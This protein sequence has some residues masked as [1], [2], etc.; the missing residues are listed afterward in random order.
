[1]SR[2]RNRSM[3]GVQHVSNLP[4]NQNLPPGPDV[5]FGAQVQPNESTEIDIGEGQPQGETYPAVEGQ[6]TAEEHK[7]KE[8]A[9]AED[10]VARAKR[11]S[12]PR[13]M[14]PDERK[15]VGFFL[16]EYIA[17]KDPVTKVVNMDQLHPDIKPWFYPSMAKNL[18]NR[19]VFNAVVD[20]ET[21][22][23]TG[24]Y[25]TE[26]GADLYF[27]MNRKPDTVAKTPGRKGRPAANSPNAAPGEVKYPD[28]LR[29]RKLVEGNPRQI[30]SHGYHAFNLYEDGMTYREYLRKAYDKT[31]RSEGTGAEFSGP[32]LHHWDWDL[33]HGFIGI[34]HE[35]QPEMLDDGSPNPNFWF[36]NLASTRKMRK[37]NKVE[38]PPV[39][40]EAEAETITE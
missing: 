18:I 22:S 17:E 28:N 32:K 35:D 10:R 23:L 40:A 39:E 12:G 33:L 15:V 38:Q 16:T 30:G 6:M 37:S 3:S 27:R 14:S 11:A 24:V 21:K 31:L 7:A 1:M 20:E 9:E 36:V 13:K 29:M 25:L 34:Y 5:N 19:G 8:D 4:E 26:V 2:K